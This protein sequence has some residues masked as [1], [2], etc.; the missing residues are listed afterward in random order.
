MNKLAH[1]NI[2]RAG[3]LFLPSPP[4][5]FKKLSAREDK[6]FFP[7]DRKAPG[8][9]WLPVMCSFQLPSHLPASLAPRLAT[10]VHPGGTLPLRPA[11]S[12]TVMTCDR[13]I[14]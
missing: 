6:C 4:P 10:P 13:L 3:T 2:L 8:P 9:G 14:P 11:R 7:A 5:H 1:S 12:M